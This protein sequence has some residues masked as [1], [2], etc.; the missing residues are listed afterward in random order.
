MLYCV[1]RPPRHDRVEERAI[2]KVGP[3]RRVHTTDDYDALLS[4][5]PRESA[6]RVGMVQGEPG[7]SDVGP[8]HREGK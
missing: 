2:P 8:E 5:Q 6:G 1:L 4:E 3:V 7:E